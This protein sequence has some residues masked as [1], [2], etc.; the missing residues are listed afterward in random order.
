MNTNE[1]QW[2]CSPY[3]WSFLSR[4]HEDEEVRDTKWW[5]GFQLFRPDFKTTFTAGVQ[6][7]SVQTHGVMT[8][9]GH[10]SPSPRELHTVSTKSCDK[11]KHNRLVCLCWFT[12]PG[13]HWSNPQFVSLSLLFV[14]SNRL[15]LPKDYR[16]LSFWKPFWGL[17]CLWASELHLWRVQVRWLK[18]IRNAGWFRSR[19]QTQ[20]KGL[21]TAKRCC[22]IITILSQY[23]S[24]LSMRTNQH[25]ERHPSII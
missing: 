22:F 4:I 9:G 14:H 18:R 13:S 11:N 7:F 15:L 23:I 20:T 5:R 1:W 21:I 3:R 17:K 10:T 24:Y 12:L 6:M 19:I 16:H 2:W 8:G 25:N